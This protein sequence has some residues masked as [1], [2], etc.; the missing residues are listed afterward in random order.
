MKYSCAGINL[1]FGTQCQG[2]LS[3]MPLGP[4]FYGGYGFCEAHWLE[5]VKRVSPDEDENVSRIERSWLRIH[6][7]PYV[8][9]TL[10]S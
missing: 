9:K 8:P 6:G 4:G 7:E 1:G 2:R 3:H 10:K 5:F